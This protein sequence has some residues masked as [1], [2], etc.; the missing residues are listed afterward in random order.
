MTRKIVKGEERIVHFLDDKQTV[1]QTAWDHVYADACGACT[2]REICGGLFDRGAAYDPAELAPQFID[3]DDV[4]RAIIE[5]PLDP[6]Y[7]LRDLAAWKRA[8]AERVVAERPAAMRAADAPPVGRI[9][10][11]GVRLYQA[12]RRRE[13]RLAEATNVVQERDDD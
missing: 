6:S 8:F 2:L 10:D 7:P 11:A 13:A 1:R 4:V 9:T 3:R 12:K 5:D